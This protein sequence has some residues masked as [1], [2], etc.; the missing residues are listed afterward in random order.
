MPYPCAGNTNS[1]SCQ[2]APA[3]V[4]TA[5]AVGASDLTFKFDASQGSQNLKEPIYPYSN[6]GACL[7]VFAPGVNILAACGSESM[8]MPRLLSAQSVL[9]VTVLVKFMP[10]L[11]WQ[12]TC[13]CCHPSYKS[14]QRIP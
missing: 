3:D 5:I 9:R 14:N 11:A 12:L 4:R 1:D 7:D 10:H 2:E 8:L 13:R 6:T